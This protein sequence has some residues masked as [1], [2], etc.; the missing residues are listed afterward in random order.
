[1]MFPFLS[2]E[3]PLTRNAPSVFRRK[4]AQAGN[5]GGSAVKDDRSGGAPGLHKRG[6]GSAE[7][8]GGGRGGRP[9]RS[10][11]ARGI[12]PL[13]FCVRGLEGRQASSRTGAKRSPESPGRHGCRDAQR[14]SWEGANSIVLGQKNG[15][16]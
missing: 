4:G 12:H 8:R 13:L 10:L 16:H 14:M 3:M 5:E 9:A 6:L 7:D 15:S 1:M 2:L 11:T